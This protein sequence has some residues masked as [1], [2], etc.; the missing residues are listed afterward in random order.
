MWLGYIPNYFLHLICATVLPVGAAFLLVGPVAASLTRSH[1]SQTALDMLGVYIAPALLAAGLGYLLNCKLC[2]RVALWVSV[3]PAISFSYELITW[4]YGNS[5][6]ET[7]WAYLF[8]VTGVCG[9]SECLGSILVPAPLMTS[10]VY[11]IFAYI[12][13]RSAQTKSRPRLENFRGGA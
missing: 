9:G 5:Y 2:H 3:L 6:G 1:S 12:G 13:I 10:A 11:A 7:L 4:N 8:G